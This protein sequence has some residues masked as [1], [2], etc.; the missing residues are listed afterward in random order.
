[1]II[2]A[3]SHNASNTADNSGSCFLNSGYPNNGPAQRK[4]ADKVAMP[5]MHMTTHISRKC[6]AKYPMRAMTPGICTFGG[7]LTCFVSDFILIFSFL[8]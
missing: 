6:K 3:V 1:M 4:S 7:E 8:L 2:N 5:I